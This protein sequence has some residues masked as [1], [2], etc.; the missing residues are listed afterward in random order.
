MSNWLVEFLRPWSFRGKVRI[1]QP[2]VP[3]SGIREAVVHGSRMRLDLEDYI[4]RMI[5]L[6]CYERWE[7]KIVRAVLQPG[8]TFLDVGANIGYFSLLASNIVGPKGKVFAVE[9]SPYVADLF[10]EAITTNQI[11]N[12][13]L[14]RCGLGA[15]AGSVSLSI[16]GRGNHTPTMLTDTGAPSLSVQVERLDDCLKEWNCNHIDL[17]KMDVEGFEGFVL[18][19]APEAFAQHR[20]RRVLCEFNNPWLQRAGSSS[21]KLYQRFR[22]LG[23]NDLSDSRWEPDKELSNRFLALPHP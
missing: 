21:A 15:S 8:M 5:Y 6:G 2:L 4:Q 10:A 17:L 18:D 13:H 7:T 12:I 3:Q 22:D 1:L 20:I 23:F 9:P 11:T 16:P 14:K 19:G